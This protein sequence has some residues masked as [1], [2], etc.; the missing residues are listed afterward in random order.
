LF[1]RTSGGDGHWHWAWHSRLYSHGSRHIGG[2]RGQCAQEIRAGM[3]RGQALDSVIDDGP[4]ASLRSAGVRE[5]A[6]ARAGKQDWSSAPVTR[7]WTEISPE[8][9]SRTRAYRVGMFGYWQFAARGFIGQGRQKQGCQDG[10]P[11]LPVTAARRMR[12]LMV[13]A[14]IEG[15][16]RRVVVAAAADT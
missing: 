3:V 9:G 15:C 11:R 10:C 6:R 16:G 2:G 13:R 1:A 5:G 4:L 12:W 7:R 14:V 8:C